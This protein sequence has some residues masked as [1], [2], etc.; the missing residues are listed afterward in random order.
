MEALHIIGDEHQSLAAILHAVRFMLK[1]VSAGRLAP[2]VPLFKAMVH[3]LEAYAEQRHH[4][5]EDLVFRV[6]AQRT[7]EGA[8]ALAE[9]GRQHAAAPQRIAV[10]QK[11]LADYVADPASF[12]G[13]AEAF[14]AYADFYRS[15][16]I[17]EEDVVLP[18]VRQHL[19]ADDW[20]AV[21]AEFRAEMQKN[22][23]DEESR[24]DFKNL[25]TK[26]VDCA[27]APIGFGPRPYS[28]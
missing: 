22:A 26:L 7:G 25:F 3:Y 2:D 14:Y 8:E 27:P 20:L 18:L 11:A 6:L 5:K 23:V 19:T 4:P 16:M 24:E 28:E 15:H 13:F 12:A 1:E 9:L 21:D 10:L 17:L